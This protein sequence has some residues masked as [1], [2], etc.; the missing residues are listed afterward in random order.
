MLD[1]KGF[2]IWAETYNNSV[3]ISDEKNVYP[4]AGYEKLMKTI[5]NNILDDKKSS[6]LDIGIGTG[7]LS[8]ELYKNGYTITGIDFSEEMIKVCK[9]KMPL[10]RL[11]QYDFTKGLP[12]ELEN[13]KFDYIISTYAMHHL[14]DNEKIILVKKLT[15]ILDNNGSIIIGD[16]GFQTKEQFDECK[17]LYNNEWDDEEYYFVYDELKNKFT[18]EYTINYNKISI[19]A[20]IIVIRKNKKI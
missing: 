15:K 6:V 13:E 18:D 7:I 4:F 1:N 9:T 16:I 3:K 17:L 5:L 8:T 14:E 12:K 10:A 11:I 2:D 19:C 20:G